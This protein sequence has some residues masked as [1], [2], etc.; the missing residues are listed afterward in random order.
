MKTDQN[1][2]ELSFEQLMEFNNFSLD[3]TT[4]K[5]EIETSIV[6][7]NNDDDD[8]NKNLWNINI[9]KANNIIINAL[10]MK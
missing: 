8:D 7:D 3:D 1:Q 6:L 10:S 9:C 5:E 2:Q 4:K